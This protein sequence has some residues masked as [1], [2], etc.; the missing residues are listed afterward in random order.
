M[1]ETFN[2]FSLLQENTVRQLHRHYPQKVFLEV[3]KKP[4]QNSIT[5]SPVSLQEPNRDF[6]CPSV[7]NI[8]KLA[9]TEERYRYTMTIL[10]LLILIFLVLYFLWYHHLKCLEFMCSVIHPELYKLFFQSFFIDIFTEIGLLQ[11]GHSP[12]MTL[13]L[14]LLEG[15]PC[16][17]SNKQAWW[18]GCPHRESPHTWSGIA[19]SSR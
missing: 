2:F 4:H 3:K 15:R 18:K 12:K 14:C 1:L 6:T 13:K 8:F 19:P 10:V 9:F 5:Y 17:H 11:Y 16:N 7:S